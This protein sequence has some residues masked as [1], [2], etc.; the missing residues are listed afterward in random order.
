[1]W[2]AT[3]V[4]KVDEVWSVTGVG[5]TKDLA[6]ASLLIKMS[7]GEDR[8]TWDSLHLDGEVTVEEHK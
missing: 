6:I 3:Y 5:Q 1:M 2:T 4:H 7:N 8:A